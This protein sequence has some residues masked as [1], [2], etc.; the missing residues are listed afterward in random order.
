MIAVYVIVALILVAL[1]G[2]ALS[3]RFVKRARAWGASSSPHPTVEV[4]S[5]TSRSAGAAIATPA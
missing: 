3:V 1:V 2:V 4:Q 5:P